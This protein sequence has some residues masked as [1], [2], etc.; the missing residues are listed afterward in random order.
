VDNFE[1]AIGAIL[2][3]MLSVVGIDAYLIITETVTRQ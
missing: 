3:A 1:V 2:L